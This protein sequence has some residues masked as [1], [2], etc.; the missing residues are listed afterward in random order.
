NLLDNACYVINMKQF[1]LSGYIPGCKAMLD[2]GPEWLDRYVRTVLVV[3]L[4]NA[5]EQAI[6]DGTGKDMPVVMMRDMS[7]QTSGEY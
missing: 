5:L 4:R 6:V 3:S 2:F 7:K 1:K